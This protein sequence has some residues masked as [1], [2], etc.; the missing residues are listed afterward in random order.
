MFPGRLS[1][2]VRT[3]SQHIDSRPSWRF[4]T[5]DREGPFAWPSGQD[6]ELDIVQKL[7]SFD[8]MEWSEIRGKH[9]HAISVNSLSR[10]AQE[11]LLAIRQDD[12]DEVFSFHLKGKS[13]IFCIRDRHIAKLLWYDPEHRV[14]PSKLKHT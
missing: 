1:K 9:H 14:C 5:V 7:H 11:R 10:A 4:S 8:S 12:I 2:Q 3:P 6:I 13:R